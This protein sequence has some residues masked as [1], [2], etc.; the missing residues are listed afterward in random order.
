MKKS[1]LTCCLTT[2]LLLSGIGLNAQTIYDFKVK[3]ASNEK[4]RTAMLDVLR[5]SMYQ[6][7]KQQ[8]IYVVDHFK[9]SGNYAY[10]TGKAQR[11]DGKEITFPEYQ[12]RGCC[13]VAVLF[14]K[15][16]GKWFIEDACIFPTDVCSYGISSRHPLAPIGIFDEIGRKKILY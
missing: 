11:K 2:L 10:F 14:I 3:N 13:D 8:F 15:K 9:A 6:Y 12:A 16:G 4:E 1:L 7:E 5:A